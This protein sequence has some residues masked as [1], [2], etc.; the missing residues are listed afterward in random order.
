MAAKYKCYKGLRLCFVASIIL[1]ANTSINA[2]SSNS[3]FSLHG[4]ALGEGISNLSGG[5]KTGSIF[6]GNAEIIAYY[7]LQQKFDHK[8]LVKFGILGST[9]TRYQGYYTDA[10]Q[11][12]SAYLSSH[13]IRISDLSYQ[14]NFHENYK[15]L[16]GIMDLNDNF[17]ITEK[18]SN[19]LNNAFSNTATLYANTQLA[20]FPYSGFGVVTSIT[21]NKTTYRLGVYQGNPQHLLTV[22]DNGYMI[23][24]EVEHIFSSFLASDTNYSVKGGAWLYQQGD[25]SVVHSS[26][27]CGLYLIAQ[28]DWN[29][30]E[31]R[32]IAAFMNLGYSNQKNKYVPYSIAMGLRSDNIFCGNRDSLSFGLG[33]I[34]ISDLSSEVAYELAYA[35][36]LYPGLMVTPDVQYIVKPSGFLP[37]AWVFMLRF[38]Y[39]F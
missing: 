8:A 19:L 23:L 28:A 32:T 20:T 36:Q 38:L 22:F 18:S 2:T 12:P 15:I 31:L 3:A 13:L 5:L 33:K 10:I 16:I 6:N 34:W 26:N 25:L 35:A 7:N 27:S 37:N 17:N 4:Y 1:V 30:N 9:D 39:Q 21:Q 29:I 14:Y 24:T 11:A